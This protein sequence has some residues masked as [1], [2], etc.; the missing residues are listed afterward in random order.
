MVMVAYTFNFMLRPMNGSVP[1]LMGVENLTGLAGLAASASGSAVTGTLQV[2]GYLVLWQVLSLWLRSSRLGAVAL[3]LILAFGLAVVS[4]PNPGAMAF[5]I[6]VGIWMAFFFTR[7]GLLASAT[8]HSIFLL[9]ISFPMTFNPRTWFFGESMIGI[10]LG[11]LPGIY[12]AWV[13]MARR[14]P[15]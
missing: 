7:F 1:A 15:A 2:I 13:A 4:G 10:A 11:A 8:M 12:G 14:R 3:G 6:A 9:S 5:G